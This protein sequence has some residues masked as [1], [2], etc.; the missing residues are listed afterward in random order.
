MNVKTTHNKNPQNSSTQKSLDLDPAQPE[1]L[2]RISCR[3]E[4]NVSGSRG[5]GFAPGSAVFSRR[6]TPG[7]KT[8]TSDEFLVPSV[9]EYSTYS[10]S[11]EFKIRQ[12]L[13]KL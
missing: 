9:R 8:N 2:I 10:L 1:V 13:I 5:A 3:N 12:A 11:I 7:A 6:V 4:E